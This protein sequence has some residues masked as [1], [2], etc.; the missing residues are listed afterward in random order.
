[1]IARNPSVV[2]FEDEIS[3]SDRARQYACSRRPAAQFGREQGRDK[4]WN[5]T[6]RCGAS[7]SLVQGP[8]TAYTTMNANPAQAYSPNGQIEYFT[9]GSGL[10]EQRSYDPQMLLPTGVKACAPCSSSSRRHRYRSLG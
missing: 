10:I 1:M 5:S 7:L 9:Y 2:D 3:S 6:W 8:T 4:S